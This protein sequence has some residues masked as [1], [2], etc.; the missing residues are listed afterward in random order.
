MKPSQL[1]TEIRRLESD[2][3]HYAERGQYWG[4]DAQGR[5][6]WQPS[7]WMERLRA[8]ILDLEAELKE[9]AD[10]KKSDANRLDSD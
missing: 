10:T 3:A 5:L 7:R 8:R 2:L 9:L 6:G 1:R 4:H